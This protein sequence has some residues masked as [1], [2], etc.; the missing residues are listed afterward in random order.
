MIFSAFLA[1]TASPTI[2]NTAD[3]PLLP[4]QCFA[5]GHP[6]LAALFTLTR[7]LQSTAWI[8]WPDTAG[9]I[10]DTNIHRTRAILQLSQH[11]AHIPYRTTR[12][13]YRI[14][15]V[16]IQYCQI[17]HPFCLINV[18]AGISTSFAMYTSIMC[19]FRLFALFTNG[20][21]SPTAIIPSGGRYSHFTAYSAS[22]V[23]MTEKSMSLSFS[24]ASSQSFTFLNLISVFSISNT[25]LLYSALL[26]EVSSAMPRITAPGH[27]NI[28]SDCNSKTGASCHW[29]TLSQLATAAHPGAYALRMPVRS[30][31]PQSCSTCWH[32]RTGGISPGAC[33]DVPGCPAAA[34][35]P[36][37]RGTP[38]QTCRLPRPPH[39]TAGSSR[40]QAD[41]PS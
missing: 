9:F 36:I 14:R 4:V 6:S 7:I 24:C 3:N 25:V 15:L 34:R 12:G 27:I 30:I 16:I 1:S 11:D 32:I 2:L 41:L 35:M 10:H 38:A 23:Y 37:W 20:S 18:S 33:H 39:P 5:R 21:I 17:W 28:Y 26:S 13:L 29:N 19:M 31:R 22:S 40:P 8:F